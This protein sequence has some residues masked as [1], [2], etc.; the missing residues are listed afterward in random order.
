MT[1]TAHV[2]THFDIDPVRTPLMARRRPANIYFRPLP[3]GAFE[4]AAR[5]MLARDVRA[6]DLVLASFS[7]FPTPGRMT[8][9]ATWVMAPYVAD[10]SPSNPACGCETCGN[11]RDICG[12]ASTVGCV[13]MARDE[14]GR[15]D[16]WDADDAVL[17]IPASSLLLPVSP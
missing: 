2:P 4:Y 10:P 16:V 9:G 3:P 7:S 13:V 1:A 6:G 8:R 11:V 12:P 17:V 15:C 5:P 14:S